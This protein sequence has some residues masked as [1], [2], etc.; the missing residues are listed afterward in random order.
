MNRDTDPTASSIDS[1]RSMALSQFDILA[2]I[3]GISWVSLQLG[4][5][6]DQIRT[7]PMGMTIGDWTGDFYDFYDT[8]ALVQCLDLVITV[9]TSVAHLAAGLGKPTWVLSRHDACWRWL[10]DRDDSPWYPT[11]RLFTQRKP[12]DWEEVLERMAV[13][14]R[15]LATQHRQHAAARVK[16]FTS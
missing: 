1:R 7:P 9:D 12:Y 13:P 4:A 5:P 3:K 2:G 10:M 11:M 15:E 14:L 8:A 6:K 16:E